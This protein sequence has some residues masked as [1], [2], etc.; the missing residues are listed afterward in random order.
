MPFNGLVEVR[1]FVQDEQLRMRCFHN[2]AA[3][4]FDPDD[5]DL[6]DYKYGL[7]MQTVTD[8]TIVRDV[9]QYRILVEVSLTLKAGDPVSLYLPV[10]SLNGANGL[11]SAS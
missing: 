8:T 4:N 9:G 7:D 2:A 11:R 5:G 1:V 3:L 6:E 10:Y